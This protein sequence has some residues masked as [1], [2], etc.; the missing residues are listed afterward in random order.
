MPASVI[1]KLVLKDSDNTGGGDE[2]R[3]LNLDCSNR[4]GDLLHQL[5]LRIRELDARVFNDAFELGWIGKLQS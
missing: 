3:M 5:R 2:I 4:D 1:F